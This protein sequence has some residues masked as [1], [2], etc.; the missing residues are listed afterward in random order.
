M[1]KPVKMLFVI[2]LWAWVSAASA[3]QMYVSPVTRITM[4][5]GPGVEHKIVA[6]LESGN[7]IEVLEYKSDWSLV[8]TDNEKQGW[9]LTR[10]LTDEQPLTIQVEKLRKENERL[11]AALEKSREEN[12]ALTKKN[13]ALKNI[14]EKYRKLEKESAD[15][16]KLDARYKAL[17]KLSEDQKQQ[18]ETLKGNL[19][20]EEILWFLSGAGVFIV[21]LILGLS[22]RKKKRYSLL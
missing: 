15:F 6:M 10:F 9:V 22:T 11:A 19:N 12:Q 18:I 7:R 8:R 20:D 16:L 13:A 3:Q 1:I 2:C 21:G 17:L 4:R 14:E 5:T